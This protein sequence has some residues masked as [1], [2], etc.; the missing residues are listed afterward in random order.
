MKKTTL[1]ILS[2]CLFFYVLQAQNPQL[3]INEFLA[4]NDTGL[5]DE[6]GEFEDWVE[7]YNAG[8]TA[9]NMAGMYF[10]DDLSEPTV[11]Q[12]PASDPAA[13]TIAPGAFLVFYF[14]KDTDQGILHVDAKL[15][16]SGEAIGLFASD[17]V[18]EIDA[19]TFGAQ[20][21]DVSEGRRPDGGPDWNF[22]STPTPNGS[23]DTPVG[24][25][26]AEIPI[27]SQ[28]GGFYNG[29]TTI[30]LSSATPG[31]SI[32]YTLDGTLPDE[33]D[34]SYQ[35]PI[36]IDE[37]T[38]VRA[39][40]YAPNADPSPV[41]TQTYLIDVEHDFIVVT[42]TTDPDNLYDSSDG[43]FTNYEEELE[44]PA[45]IQFFEPDGTLAFSQN[46]EIE[47]HGKGSLSL[48][49]KSLKMKAKASLGNEFFEHSIFPQLEFEQYR[50]FVMRQSGQDWNKTMFRD[51]LE[52][53]LMQDVS[54]LNGL[55]QQPDLDLQSFRPAILYI[56]GEYWG[57]QNV[58]EQ[59]NWR[60]ID[61]HY[62]IGKEEV[63]VVEDIDELKTGDL[64]EWDAFNQ[65][66]EENNFS[67]DANF[68]LLKERA[69]VDHFIDYMLHGIICDNNDWP[70]NNNRHW[71]E[72]SP[73]GKWR[74]LSK[75]FD[76]GFGLR[77][78]NSVWNSG[79]FTTD[80][81]EI[82]LAEDSDEYYNR[83]PAT[84]LLRRIMENEQAKNYFINRGADLLNTVFTRERM[85]QR[86]DDLENTFI[87]EMQQHFDKWQSGWNGHA[88]N[89]DVLRTF[90]E[91]RT[92]E[93]REHFADN[94]GE[95]NGQATVTLNAN[96]AEGGSI[97]WSTLNVGPALFPWQGIYFRG[98]NVPATAQPAR[99]YLFDSWSGAANGNTLAVSV[100]INASTEN[101]TANFTLGS[102]STDAIVIN[103]I[104][105]NSP[106]T[107]DPADWIELYN[108]NN[109]AV[110]ISAWYL[111][112]ESGEFYGFPANT[113]MEAGA[114]FVLAEDALA[115]NSIYPEVDQVFGSFG[116]GPNAFGLS[117]K[118]ERITLKNAA[119][120]LI[121]E[122]E[123][124]DKSPWPTAADGEGPTL[125]LIQ[126]NLDNAL[127]AS[128]AGFPA[129]PGAINQG[130]LALFC[131]TDIEI[132]VLPG[133]T[134]ELVT[135][136]L[137]PAITVCAS[138][139]TNLIQTAG[140]NSGQFFPIG[141]TTVSY[142]VSDECGNTSA[143]SFEVKVIV[144][145]GTLTVECP[146]NLAVTTAQGA[147]SAM[148]NWSAP[149]ANS[150]CGIGTVSVAQID[151]PASGTDLAIGTYAVTYRISDD[152]GN[153]ME[154][155]FQV[156]IIDGNSGI[157]LSCPEDIS[158][159]LPLGA[160]SVAVNWD[161]PVAST[162][163]EEG[164]LVNPN[165]GTNLAGFTFVGT[166]EGHE[167]Y[168]S[169]QK[170]RWTTA[171]ANCLALGGHLAVINDAEENAFI[172]NN[173]AVKVYIGLSDFN[174]EGNPEW[175]NGDAVTYSNIE[176]TN[177]NNAS[178][179][180]AYF[181]PWNARWNWYSNAVF[182]YYLLEL[183]CADESGLQIQ[184]SSGPANGAALTAGTYTVS[185]EA[186]DNC[187]G[188]TQCSF[189]I[190]VEGNPQ[191]L[192]ITC[193]DDITVFAPSGATGTEVFWNL[194][195]AS[196][197]N[198]LGAIEVNQTQGAPLGSFFPVG[199]YTISYEAT[200][201][202][203]NLVSCSFALT[204]LPEVSNGDYCASEGDKPWEE[205]IGNFSFG[206]LNQSSGKE[207]YADFTDLS[208]LVEAGS[209]YP[210]SI[211]P[212]FSWTQYDTY[213]Q[214]WIDFNQDFDFNDPNEL[215]YAY[216][217]PAQQGGSDVL[218]L[219]D[220]VSIPVD[221]LAGN[222]RMRVSMSRGNYAAACEL[223]E[224]GEVEDYTISVISSDVVQRSEH[225]GDVANKTIANKVSHQGFHVY[226]NPA[227]DH[228]MIESLDSDIA[229]RQ[230]EIFNMA[231]QRL[232]VQ[233]VNLGQPI[234]R[235]Q[236]ND[237][238]RGMYLLRLINENGE[239][240]TLKF[241]VQ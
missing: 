161:G 205:Y 2:Q 227:R 181:Q 8:T 157:D 226:P 30:S 3:L 81:I 101:L 16:A 151:G 174:S 149:S 23:N 106:D 56:N 34:S 104:N 103:E 238:S 83:P 82:C 201:A 175:V 176:P 215:V 37:T 192:A 204:V 160:E 28:E 40:A 58:R 18:T 112:D 70:G 232:F 234:I 19:Y 115:F 7:I 74:W 210:M 26:V 148:A 79:D 220:N 147:N 152:C 195:Q 189:D 172:A 68:E 230:L 136:T 217:R 78:I 241:T 130:G 17:G 86:I 72:R 29:T 131:P 134:G 206:N 105:Y 221:A 140:P 73:E 11:W 54:D 47:L 123:Y 135:W 128:W 53:G 169:E 138:G 177:D 146:D 141:T 183:D 110:D 100:P 13:T 180:F 9:V 168:L 144:D 5:T 109:F 43:L 121:D 155:N 197:D 87:P 10:T 107:P 203:A 167:Y 143:C 208:A 89:V 124:D 182:K 65:F 156:E 84:L 69:D 236:L 119:G 179:N 224:F 214:V 59:M 122:V 239:R 212:E 228:L 235:H 24:T 92:A 60:Y 196:N 14:D 90:A 80:M 117:G 102:T 42:M 35:G 200:D 36:Q 190:T 21:A 85:L 154:C 77:P 113:I 163:C 126:A 88:A 39:I 132:F 127:A 12:I 31:A 91:G 170:V 225:S 209:T 207:G 188:F 6:A 38:A 186:S 108:P 185:Y 237:Y 133:A 45:H 198:C 55:I 219:T 125:Q 150:T 20:L 1:L 194:P 15:G 145:T 137:D 120:L 129:T 33:G 99:G 222:T 49:Q 114:Y 27:A 48:P 4:S 229:I 94:F 164:G 199:N 62:G 71:R 32:Y 52:Q 173:V 41:M 153:Q 118:G 22:F 95:I 213:F 223:F 63:D 98:N 67:T 46:I 76:F 25:G 142:E 184:Q 218:P 193:P 61:T 240:F 187:G 233:N 211:Q 159:V 96:P 111:E 50:S 165:C 75:D 191:N 64:V 51:A 97:Q 171:Q 231:G 44:K 139:V 178:N 216:I 116:E 57:I 166:Y 93:V 162:N 66:L 202:C 158:L